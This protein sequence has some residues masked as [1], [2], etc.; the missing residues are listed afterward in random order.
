MAHGLLV[1]VNR[2]EKGETADEYVAYLGTGRAFSD[3]RNVLRVWGHLSVIASVLERPIAPDMSR[4]A[5]GRRRPF[6]H[7]RRHLRLHLLFTR[8]LCFFLALMPIL[9]TAA[10]PTPVEV[11]RSS[12]EG[13]RLAIQRDSV[14]IEQDPS[15]VIP[16]IREHIIP[17]VD[18]DVFAKLILG[19]HWQVASATQ[20]AAFTRALSD[21][22]LH[23]Y[24]VHV[25][26]YAHAKV[27]YLGVVPVGNNA[28]AVLV[29]TQV[30]TTHGTSAQ[31]DYRMMR[32]NGNWKAIDAS[33]DGI[34]IVRTY[35]AAM[36]EE[37][38]RVGLDGVMQRLSR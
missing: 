11:I 9:S 1:S 32:R 36:H 29:R 27:A 8:M 31:V 6:Q 2:S 24:G 35:R 15:R 20:R 14:A 21:A 7:G 34:S 38:G 30:S 3:V 28:N 17:N 18:T 33:V 13:L 10:Q 25:T 12:V 4:L 16:L 5:P 26:Q 22:L 37:I 23:I 19:Q